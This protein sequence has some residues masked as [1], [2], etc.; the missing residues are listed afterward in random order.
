MK[1]MVLAAGEG[2]RLRPLTGALP[3]PILPLAN[4]PLLEH[5]LELL[6]R[7]GVSEVVIN[8]F[9]RP[10]PIRNRLGDGEKLGLR[11]HYSVEESLLGTAGAV[12]KVASFFDET[13]LVLYGDNLVIADLDALVGFHRERGG[14]ATIALFQAG[15][16]SACG[17]VEIDENARVRRFVEKPPPEQVT[18]NTA[19]AGVYVLEP[20]AL[21][22]I[23]GPVFY[24]FGGQV[25]P[26]MLAA[27]EKLYAR[28]LGGYLRDIGT[29][30]GYLAAHRDLLTQF[31][32]AGVDPRAV[33]AP[34]AEIGPAVT[35]AGGVLVRDGAW[36]GPW[37]AIGPDC[38]IGSSAEVRESVLWDRVTL[39]PHSRVDS[40]V[41][42]SGCQ[43]GSGARIEPGAVLGAGCTIADG[44]VVPAGTRLAEGMDYRG[45]SA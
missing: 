44:A 34:T 26:E 8:L 9:H 13:F 32:A 31:G 45:A 38:M 1:A 23:P 33:V 35:V 14:M 4:R 2:T 28:L 19:N 6:A 11:I 18:T 25:F 37:A 43:V 22:Y 20:E 21:Q 16:P 15:N 5:T 41:I 40:A 3:K 36:I 29:V 30:E 10:D 12:K 17:I 39:G 7:H 24:D 27:G 42:A